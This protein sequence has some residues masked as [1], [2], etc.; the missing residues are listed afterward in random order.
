MVVDERAFLGVFGY[1][2]Y[3][4]LS[5]IRVG[6]F[7]GVA[8][9]ADFFL[10]LG[11]G[12]PTLIGVGF[13]LAPLIGGGRSEIGH[14]D[15]GIH[16]AAAGILLALGSGITGGLV[17]AMSLASVGL[18]SGSAVRFGIPRIG[19]VGGRLLGT[20]LCVGAT[21]GGAAALATTSFRLI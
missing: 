19:I 10:M 1:A 3:A 6:F 9:M 14:I 20:S 13:L 4:V 12:W 16:G 5:A 21:A 17:V 18:V 2:A 15:Y 7:S 8:V 11:L